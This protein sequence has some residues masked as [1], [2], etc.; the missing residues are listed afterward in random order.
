MRSRPHIFAYLAIVVLL[1]MAMLAG[2]FAL[3]LQNFY[4]QRELQSRLVS[5]ISS[6]NMVFSDLHD[7]SLTVEA[8][9]REWDDGLYETYLAQSRRLDEDAASLAGLITHDEEAVQAMRRLR[10]FNEYQVDLVRQKKEKEKSGLFLAT[11]YVLEG[12]AGHSR[13]LESLFQT[14]LTKESA[15]YM[16]LQQTHMRMQL[17]ILGAGFLFLAVCLLLLARSTFQLGRSMTRVLDNLDRLSRHDWSAPDLEGAS[18]IETA[19]VFEGINHV[20]RELRSYFEQQKRQAEVEKQLVEAQVRALRSQVNPHFLFNALHSIGMASLVESPE[21]VMKM[22]ESTGK[23]LRYSL[24]MSDSFV[25][26]GD[27]V[28]IVKQYLYLQSMCHERPIESSIVLDEHTEDLS[29]LPMSIQPLVENSMKHGYKDSG[30]EAFHITV[31]AWMQGTSLY[32][33]VSD[34]GVGFSVDDLGHAKR[35]EGIGLSN[36]QERM[37]MV[38]G[39]DG[40]CTV[41][42]SVGGGAEIVLAFPQ[43]GK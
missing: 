40:L 31:H 20:K 12:I 8:W 42:S 33:S 18:F 14:E 13:F 30:E 34:D 22:V 41:K 43:G 21:V 19:S 16:D 38:Y 10:S 36:I 29:I 5:R 28:S 27:E 6:Y 7:L 39:S 9:R 2:F 24:D 26:L 1:S 17:A 11:S 25:S 37:R 23:I 15:S 32:V 35:G 3:T 4:R